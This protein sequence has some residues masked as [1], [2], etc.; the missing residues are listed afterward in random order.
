[1]WSAA[2]PTRLTAV[3]AGIYQITALILWAP[4]SAGS[5]RSASISRNGGPAVSVDVRAPSAITG[6][7][8]SV[9]QA[10]NAGDYVELT[11]SQDT[12]DTLLPLDIIG[13]GFA[14]PEFMMSRVP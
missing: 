11:V 3:V 5:E 1:M 7:Q 4:S 10:M 12:Q 8:A 6:N 13:G 14:S 9:L 2:F